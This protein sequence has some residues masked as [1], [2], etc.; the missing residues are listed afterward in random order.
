MSSNTL[1]I[2]ACIKEYASALYAQQFWHLS[3]SPMRWPN[4]EQV[5]I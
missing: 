3:V 2:S 5:I 4:R 1:H